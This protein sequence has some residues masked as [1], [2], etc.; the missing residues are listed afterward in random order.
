MAVPF[1]QIDNAELAEKLFLDDGPAGEQVFSEYFE[2]AVSGSHSLTATGIDTVAPTVANPALAQVH[3]LA[4]TGLATG[5]PTVA[6]PALAQLHALGAIG[7]ATAPPVTGAPA[8]AQLHVL[9]AIG[10]TVQPQID[11]PSLGGSVPQ[12][13]A[14]ASI[15]YRRLRE[16]GPSPVPPLPRPKPVNVSLVAVGIATAAPTLGRPAL[17]EEFDLQALDD[18]LMMIAA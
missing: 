17:T 4:A 3:A 2:D 14:G 6:A 18:D 15:A 9:G 7:I 11:Q 1:P 8:L 13:S 5:A 10:I 12:Y 16:D